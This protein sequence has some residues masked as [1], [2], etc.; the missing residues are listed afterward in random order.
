MGQ[1]TSKDEQGY[2]ICGQCNSKIYHLKSENPVIPCP[3]CGWYHGAKKKRE[4]PA[5]IKL[6]LPDYE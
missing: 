5:K 6:N 2:Y 3:D 4:L 1:R